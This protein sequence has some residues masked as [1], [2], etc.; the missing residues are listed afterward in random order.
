[1]E[2]PL[3][4]LSLGVFVG[5]WSWLAWPAPPWLLAALGLLTLLLMPKLERRMSLVLI[6]MCLGQV[7][8]WTQ[9]HPG[10]LRSWT[11]GEV[12]SVT[13]KA[14]LLLTPEGHLWTRLWPKPP[15]VGTRIA[16]RLN[17]NTPRQ[18]LPGE[19]PQSAQARLARAP[20]VRMKIWTPLDVQPDPAALPDGLNHPGLLRA[21]GSGDRSEVPPNVTDLLRRTGTIHL[22]AISGLHV[23]MI[24]TMAGLLV[25]VMTRSLTRGQW[26][27]AARILPVLS[28]AA[29][30]IGYGEVVHW[31][32]STQR[33]AVMVV[34]VGLVSLFG[35][36]PCPWQ[37]LGLAA[38]GILAA[39]PSQ[40]ASLGFLMSFG[41]VG[42]IVLGMPTLAPITPDGTPWLLR[43]AIQ[44][45]G[46]TT[47]ATLGTL[48]VT[49]WVFQS[50]A[51]SGPL[52]NLLAVPMFTGLVV[53]LAIIGTIGPSDVQ[54]PCLWLADRAVSAALLWIEAC[55]LGTLTPAAGPAAAA[56]LVA[57]VATLTRPLW[58]VV[59]LLC[60]LSPWRPA[61]DGLTVTFPA[62][63]QGSAV[64]VQWPDGR[65]WLVDGGPPG[66]RV[67]HWL[68]RSGVRHLDR[69]V[70]SHPDN[71]HFGGLLPVISGLSIG[72][73][74]TAR[75]P[76][77]EEHDYRALWQEVHARGVTVRTPGIAWTDPDQDN[78]RGLVLTIRHGRHR[79]LLLGDVSED[80][81][82]RIAGGMPDMTVVQVSHH[83]SRT[84]SNPSLIA[85]ASAH[86]AVIQS[87]LGNRFGHP[88]DQ[89]IARWEGTKVRRTDTLGSLRFRSDGQHVIAQYW[90]PAYGWR[91]LPNQR[92]EFH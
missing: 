12:Q 79:F 44:G 30:A 83:G 39:Q 90:D 59:C 48:P 1:M 53:P 72:E 23:G 43:T 26:A 22:L 17:P 25:W 51:I 55:D 84:S 34:A 2:R 62:V 18:L 68:R 74:W 60:A 91:S 71:D 41:A 15:P 33:A 66:S 67:L 56:A 3:A 50:V 27:H 70:L 38:L 65:R 46:A 9:P 58:A 49:A 63:G 64:L 35:R 57:A 4:W 88:H 13:G 45:M 14:A 61:P 73:F 19:W 92:A 10:Q 75:P 40:A 36:R 54:A 8:V 21:L 76:M 52:A 89:T 16:G 69:V 77:I 31:P 42:A 78:D 37:I 20:W 29:A 11:T 28:A 5:V 7:L 47:F 86:T 80:V 82:D 87:G 81:E 24:S 32:V 85:A 6:G